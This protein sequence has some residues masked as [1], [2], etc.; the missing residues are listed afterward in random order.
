MRSP[1]YH[2]NAPPGCHHASSGPHSRSRL[3]PCLWLKN[4]REE[5]R[6]QGIAWWLACWCRER[7]EEAGHWPRKA[8]WAG[9]GGRPSPT[10][11]AGW[12]SYSSGAMLPFFSTE[13]RAE[14]RLENRPESRQRQR[15][16][17]KQTLSFESRRK[18]V[19]KHPPPTRFI[20]TYP[21]HCNNKY[22]CYNVSLSL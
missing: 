1:H 21:T 15:K 19:E 10:F 2:S 16:L 22:L 6:R 17:A 20:L 5:C 12:A 3:E 7:G 8:H 13:S 4:E 9:G 11:G 14:S 18:K